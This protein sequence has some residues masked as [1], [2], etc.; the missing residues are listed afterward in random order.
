ME[1]A[2]Q[3]SGGSKAD[4]DTLSEA[5][6]RQLVT[7]TG[8]GSSAAVA[9]DGSG[10]GQHQQQQQQGSNPADSGPSA[11]TAEG[12]ATRRQGCWSRGFWLR[13]IVMLSNLARVAQGKCSAW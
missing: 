7:G 6:F 10:S 5:L 9:S 12:C 2:Q 4:L 11:A 3:A 13:C 8:S 1:Q